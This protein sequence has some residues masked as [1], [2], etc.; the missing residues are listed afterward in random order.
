MSL[1]RL[2]RANAA[3]KKIVPSQLQTPAG[4]TDA[5]HTCVHTPLP[6][7]SSSLGVD[8]HASISSAHDH[9]MQHYR[10][11]KGGREER[12]RGRQTQ[13][14]TM[15]AISGSLPDILPVLPILTCSC[16]CAW[17]VPI[18]LPNFVPRLNGTPSTVPK[19]APRRSTELSVVSCSS[20]FREPSIAISLSYHH[21]IQNTSDTTAP[22]HH[23]PQDAPIGRRTVR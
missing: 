2:C 20:H 15:T 7:S 18:S 17:V 13:T 16:V 14:V 19:S 12:E 1:E 5:G 22:Q 4:G 8:T 6:P 11:P 23:S 9:L 3:R 21:P 10:D